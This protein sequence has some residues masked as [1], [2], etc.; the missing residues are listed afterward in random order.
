MTNSTEHLHANGYYGGP[1]Q[2]NAP[3]GGITEEQRV[4]AICGAR[5]PCYAKYPPQHT[6]DPIAYRCATCAQGWL[7]APENAA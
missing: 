6:S 3:D 2:W 5:C 4:C 1:R 7:S